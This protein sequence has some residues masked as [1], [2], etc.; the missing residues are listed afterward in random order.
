MGHGVLGCVWGWRVRERLT[1]F[2]GDVG[3]LVVLYKPA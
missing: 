1:P 2:S 3:R